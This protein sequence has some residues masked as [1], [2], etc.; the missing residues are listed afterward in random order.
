VR[1]IWYFEF[2]YPYCYIGREFRDPL[3]RMTR[4]QALWWKRAAQSLS[5][6][7]LLWLALTA[8]TLGSLVTAGTG[9]A[10]SA[11]LTAA[12]SIGT[13]GKLKGAGAPTMMPGE[14]THRTLGPES[15]E[16]KHVQAGGTPVG[17][18]PAAFVLLD[19]GDD[20]RLAIAS[21]LATLDFSPTAF[22]A[23]APPA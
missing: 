10:P 16:A 13:T 18:I 21:D 4:D 14:L 6:A 23:R 15:T 20:D 8:V 22:Q 7:G 9:L 1:Q 12:S 2:R 5:R 17:L 11:R 19:S 3:S